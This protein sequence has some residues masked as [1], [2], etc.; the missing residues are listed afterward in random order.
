MA[1][2]MKQLA[3]HEIALMKA[4]GFD[5]SAFETQI[6]SRPFRS[7]ARMMGQFFQDNTKAHRPPE[8]SAEEV[9]DR[10][11]PCVTEIFRDFARLRD[12]LAVHESKVHSRWVK[13]SAS[14]RKSILG[15]AWPH[16]ATT[17]R[18]NLQILWRTAWSD[19]RPILPK[20]SFLFADFNLDDLANK[21]NLLLLL[22]SRSRHTP[23][24]F[25]NSDCLIAQA[26]KRFVDMF[27]L[28]DWAISMKENSY[29]KMYQILDLKED[30][31]N[32]FIFVAHKA[33]LVFEIQ[34]RILT[35]LVQCCELVL[36]DMPLKAQDLARGLGLAKSGRTDGLDVDLRP[37]IDTVIQEPPRRFTDQ[38]DF[39][40][41]EKFL[42]AKREE[43]EDHI[44]LL[45][46]DPS[47]LVG[48]LIS[49]GKA[50]ENFETAMHRQ[51]AKTKTHSRDL[52]FRD[53]GVGQVI[54]SAYTRLVAWDDM[55]QRLLQVIGL[56]KK[57][58]RQLSPVEVLPDDYQ[59]AIGLLS[60]EVETVTWLFKMDLQWAF[61]SSKEF[62]QYF[63]WNGI[64]GEEDSRTLNILTDNIPRND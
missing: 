29:G 35:F 44:W 7:Q 61:H 43:S 24:A 37:C 31:T 56:R 15:K 10:L 40:R 28:P 38:F 63:S 36:H 19:A 1:E 23:A 3:R 4:G 51:V 52:G 27:D 32:P 25:V 50:V 59:R 16:L 57:Y 26:G 42:F 39:D 22:D 6:E 54:Y 64:P 11:T 55:L 46:Q 48:S 2:K 13:K 17:H 18:P 20:D 12:I 53:H 41:L 49:R 5:A 45:R 47:Y 9:R 58:E 62:D 8:L 14:Q 33:L 60:A 34:Q 21:K 30:M